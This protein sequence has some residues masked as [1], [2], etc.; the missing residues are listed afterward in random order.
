MG[1]TSG[2]GEMITLQEHMNSY[3]F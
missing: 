3:T 2:A 1:V